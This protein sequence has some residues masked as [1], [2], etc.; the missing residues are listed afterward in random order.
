MEQPSKALQTNAYFRRN[1]PKPRQD[2]EGNSIWDGKWQRCLPYARP[3][4]ECKHSWLSDHG[5]EGRQR[6][7]NTWCG[8]PNRNRNEVLE[9]CRKGRRKE[10]LVLASSVGKVLFRRCSFCGTLTNQTSSGRM[11]P[12]LWPEVTPLCFI[13]KHCR[14]H[15][16]CGTR[17]WAQAL[18]V[19]V[20]C[21]TTELQTHSPI[22]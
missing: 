14:T 1:E 13:P 12:S 8:Y 9:L 7:V 16:F 17:D 19:P 21:S 2:S 15:P 22:L 18:H 4:E 10:R 6:N 3:K 11:T 5:S 20:K